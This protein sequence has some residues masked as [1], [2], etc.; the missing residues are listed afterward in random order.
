MLSEEEQQVLLSI[1]RESIRH[2]LEHGTAL[3]PAREDYVPALQEQRPVFVT[4]K[5]KS[6]LR[7]CIGTTESSTSIVENVA[8]YAF[9]AAFHDPRFAP[10]D[11]DEFDQITV[12]LSILSANEPV[13]FSSESD[14]LDQLRPGID[15]L[16]IEKGGCRA[17]FLPSVWEMLPDTQEFLKHLKLKANI[18]V[19]ET[20]SKA[21]R[22]H[23]DIIQDI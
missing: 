9:R 18:A 19:D 15:G 16:I 21:W 3:K 11:K 6:Q 2:G 14:L 1:A 23:A 7:G 5:I 12:S 17:T 13:V 10:L 20:P 4:L 8:E 22:Y